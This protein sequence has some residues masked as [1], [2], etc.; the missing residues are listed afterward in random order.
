MS[1][2][3]CKT[4]KSKSLWENFILSRNEANFLQSWNWGI[5]QKI[6][7]KKIFRFGIYE[8]TKLIGCAL[9]VKEKAKRGTYLTISGGPIIDWGNKNYIKL[10]LHFIK[11]RGLVENCDFIR[12]RPQELDK[13]EN[14]NLLKEL[15]FKMAPMHL[16]ADLTLQIDLE[17]SE[18]EILAKMRK[19][20]RYQI[21][22]ADKLN[23]KVKHSKDSLDMREFYEHQ[24]HLAK[25]HRFVPFS[26]EFLH[27]QFKTFAVDN[28]ASLFHAYQDDVLLASAFII[29]YNQE[30]VYHYGV[31]TEKN[32]LLPGS[33][34][35]QW[36][37]I[38][39]ARNRGMKKYN[40]WG[41]APKKQKDHRFA[42]VSLFKRGFGGDEINYLPTHDLPLSKKYVLIRAFEIVRKKLRK[43]N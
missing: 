33:Y 23:I 37:A 32:N 42:G 14:R 19:N 15:D 16:T 31:S 7:G 27:Q 10:L 41:V 12:I 2:L 4:V 30:A 36:A 6:L 22:K 25:K 17:R 21:R 29:F 39:A 34:A 24:L 5:F 1:G 13:H 20:T 35:C 26:Y 8:D 11:E 9:S 3:T 40:L 28:Q 18:E 43:L 38:K